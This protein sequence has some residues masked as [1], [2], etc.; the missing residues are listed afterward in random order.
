MI[1]DLNDR[2]LDLIVEGLIDLIDGEDSQLVR[3]G[4]P[5]DKPFLDKIR[6]VKVLIDKIDK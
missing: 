1:I 2:E 5:E 6:E 4:R 3:D